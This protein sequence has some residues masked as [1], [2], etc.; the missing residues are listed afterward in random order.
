MKYC[1]FGASWTEHS[2]SKVILKIYLTCLCYYLSSRIIMLWCKFLRRFI[3]CKPVWFS[4]FLVFYSLSRTNT[5]QN[6]TN[7]YSKFQIN[8][9]LLSVLFV[10][11]KNFAAWLSLPHYR[12]LKNYNASRVGISRIKCPWQKKTKK[13]TSTIAARPC[14]EYI[15]L[16]NALTGTTVHKMPLPRKSTGICCLKVW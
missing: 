9:R 7:I 16:N 10:G 8:E 6:K 11:L 4:F 13:N 12:K 2:I 3:Y 5:V 1:R 14:L 15:S